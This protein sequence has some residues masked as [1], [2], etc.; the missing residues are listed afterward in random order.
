MAGELWFQFDVSVNA[1]EYAGGPGTL[2]EQQRG[3]REMSGSLPKHV[4]RSIDE[5]RAALGFS[6]LWGFLPSYPADSY[7]AVQRKRSLARDRKRK[8][9]ARMKGGFCGR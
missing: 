7:Y 4:K 5:Y 6:S 3:I 8:Q 2:T 9:R 1:S